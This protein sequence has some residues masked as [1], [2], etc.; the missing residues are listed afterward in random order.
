MVI[1]GQDQDRWGGGYQ[2]EQ[3]FRGNLTRLNIW[4]REL[5]STEVIQYDNCI[6][7][8]DDSLIQWDPVKWKLNGFTV[9]RK[10]NQDEIC[11]DEIFRI[12]LSPEMKYSD[13]LM[14]CIAFKSSLAYPYDAADN[15]NFLELMKI[16]SKCSGIWLGITDEQDDGDWISTSN[17][18][19]IYYTNWKI[20]Q[21]NG[22]TSENIGV[23]NADGRWLDLSDRYEYCSICERSSPFTIE[24]KGLCLDIEIDRKYVI[25]G[26][27]S[28][29]P[30]FRGYSRSNISWTG[31][32]WQITDSIRYISI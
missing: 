14:S 13:S 11:N 18:N 31:K 27:S 8:N 12:L 6:L 19:P 23:L 28:E 20:G 16:N 10:I 17:G 21:P 30:F 32:Y 15:E 7:N 4:S 26:Y 25:S 29:K 3:S 9:I 5:T 24:I 22:H 1:I 2:K